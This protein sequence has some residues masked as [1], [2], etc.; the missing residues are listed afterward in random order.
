[1]DERKTLLCQQPDFLIQGQ[2]VIL[3]VKVLK[4]RYVW[5]N[6]KYELPHRVDQRIFEVFP[7]CK[8]QRMGLSVEP[9]NKKKRTEHTKKDPLNK[10][11]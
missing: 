1:M 4:R 7:L 6:L 5:V 3:F 2:Q 11:P 10:T 9:Y 8:N